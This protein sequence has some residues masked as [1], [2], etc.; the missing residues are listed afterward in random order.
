MP[1]GIV[2]DRP[3]SAPGSGPV[4]D[5]GRRSDR[6]GG[7]GGASAPAQCQPARHGAPR[8]AGSRARI[9]LP[10]LALTLALV[11]SPTLIHAESRHLLQAIRHT[12]AAI[13]A[14][15]AGNLPAL[16]EEAA[17]AHG[18]ADASDEAEHNVMVE[19][20]EIM[21]EK[22]VAKARDQKVQVSVVYA[23]DALINLERAA[24]ALGLPVEPPASR[25]APTGAA[26]P[27]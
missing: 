5:C 7:S 9:A 1:A 4:I 27:R 11:L 18:E 19:N 13:Q 17:L 24:A 3:A 10:N 2:T 8:T 26:N 15:N 12:R 16:L 14:G 25:S 23:R 21:L 6:G 20:G 22:T